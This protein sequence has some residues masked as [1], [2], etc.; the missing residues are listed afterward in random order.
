M[1]S[2][3]IVAAA[4]LALLLQ[5]GLTSAHAINASGHCTGA[6]VTDYLSSDRRDQTASATF[7]NLTDGKLTFITSGTGCVVILFSGSAAVSSV[8]DGFYDLMHVRTL[9][10]GTSNCAPGTTS[11]IFLSAR[12]PGPA[13][14]SS[15]TRICKNVTA[16]VHTVQV[17]F[18]NETGAPD[19][20]SSDIAGHI[21]TVTHN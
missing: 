19:G 5:G 2:A 14:A 18:R 3:F 20:G 16:G 9:L 10:D 6:T 11:D 1:K 21:L 7:V 12:N 15:I 8:D 17:Q 13:N 4:V